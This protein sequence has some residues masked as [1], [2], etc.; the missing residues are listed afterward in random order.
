MLAVFARSGLPMRQT[1][2]GGVVHVA[3]ALT[4]EESPDVPP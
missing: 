1:R 4:K 3:L 2:D